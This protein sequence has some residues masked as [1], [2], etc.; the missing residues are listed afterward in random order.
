MLSPSKSLRVTFLGPLASF[1]H[2]SANSTTASI[3]P[4]PSFADAFAAIQ[5]NE[6]DYAVIPFENSTNG[7]V[8]QTLDLLADRD[9]R[10]NDIVVCGEY[11]LTVHH[12][13]LV[14]KEDATSDASH[15]ER[16]YPRISKL[17]THPQ[18]WGQCERFLSKHFHGVERQDAPSTS[19]AAS[20][21]AN[22][23]CALHDVNG[24]GEGIQAAIASSFAAT[25]HNLSI[26]ATNIEDRAGNTTRFLVLRNI[27]NERTR[28]GEAD[29]YPPTPSSASTATP[30]KLKT[31]ISFMIAHEIPGALV[32]AL[33]IFRRYGLNLTSIMP[34]PGQIRP[35]QYIFFVECERIRGVHQEDVVERTMRELEGKTSCCRDLGSW[36][37]RLGEGKGE[38][39][40]GKGEE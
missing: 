20:I 34:R 1:S 35:W 14:R 29:F 26:L 6:A 2:Q 4:K 40:I 8:V 21:V 39:E 38:E 19:K 36:G 16:I 5:S 33:T 22:T 10:Y 17:Y 12:C 25:Y 32:D 27:N 28:S 18:A 7:S 31:L 11:Y 23:G 37:D 3:L 15:P 24:S 9:G 13:L 30:S